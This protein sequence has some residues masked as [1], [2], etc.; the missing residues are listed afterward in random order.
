M[1]GSQER[2][3]GLLTEREALASMGLSAMGV[4]LDA[5]HTAAHAALPEPVAEPAPAAPVAWGSPGK[6][7]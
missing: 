7:R 6:P 5:V 4:S 3:L 1:P 2:V